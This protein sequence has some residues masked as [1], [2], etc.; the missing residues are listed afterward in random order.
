MC[1]APTCSNEWTTVFNAA[2]VLST[3]SDDARAVHRT[4]IH[5][6]GGVK[7]SELK[8][9][10]KNLVKDENLLSDDELVKPLTE[11]QFKTKVLSMFIPKSVVP[12]WET[13]NIPP[14]LIQQLKDTSTF[15]FNLSSDIHD[16][17]VKIEGCVEGMDVGEDFLNILALLNG[18]KER[19]GDCGVHSYPDL[20]TG[21]AHLG[22]EVAIVI[23]RV[24]DLDWGSQAPEDIIK[25]VNV[26]EE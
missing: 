24:S 15:L 2:K 13:F 25:K 22:G 20:A 4:L 14:S 18:L 1:S 5:Q 6:K 21:L 9:P 12:H 3:N 11:E 17:Q 10:K 8:T 26:I 19:I 7:V 16:L 23:K